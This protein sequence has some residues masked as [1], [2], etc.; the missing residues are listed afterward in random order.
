M[1]TAAPAANNACIELMPD[2]VATIIGVRG[3]FRQCGGAISIPIAT[4]VLHSV[5]SMSDGFRFVFFA[6]SILMALTIPCIFLMPSSCQ[7]P[8]SKRI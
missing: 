4:L 7:V 6:S 2:R 5:H 8:P 3:M 1:G